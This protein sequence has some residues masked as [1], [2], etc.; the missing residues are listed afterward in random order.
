MA[1]SIAD[2]PDA[3]PAPVVS[4]LDKATKAFRLH[5]PVPSTPARWRAYAGNRAAADK[6]R[7][8]D[9]KAEKPG[10]ESPESDGDE[11]DVFNDSIYFLRSIRRT[12]RELEGELQL[13]AQSLQKGCKVLWCKAAFEESYNVS[14]ASHSSF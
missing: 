9:R 7:L 11:W 12:M 8:R 1:S 10:Y 13:P 2:P 4:F 14:M 3:Q 6:I 5:H